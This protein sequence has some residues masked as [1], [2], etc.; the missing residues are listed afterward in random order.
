ME[1]SVIQWVEASVLVTVETPHSVQVEN[2]V[3]NIAVREAAPAAK[4][5]AWVSLA[6]IASP[7]IQ[8]SLVSNF[9]PALPQVSAFQHAQMELA[10]VE[11]DATP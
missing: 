2:S 5:L 3:H 11:R 10:Q 7:V 8:A 9:K 4:S 6:P 1:K